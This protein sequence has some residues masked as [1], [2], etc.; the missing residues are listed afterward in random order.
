MF[1]KSTVGKKMVKIDFN[2][3]V[4]NIAQ[5]K[6]SYA[7]LIRMRNKLVAG[8]AI[9]F[10]GHVIKLEENK[11]PGII[12][13]EGCEFYTPESAVCDLCFECDYLNKKCNRI[14]IVKRKI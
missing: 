11:E 13:C 8:K 7:M 9:R 14:V 2:K 12:P 5:R 10:G 4:M 3:F 1:V 6:Y